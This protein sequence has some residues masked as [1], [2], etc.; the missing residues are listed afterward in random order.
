MGGFLLGCLFFPFQALWEFS[1]L[2][3]KKMKKEK[4]DKRKR[5][6]VRGFNTT[7]TKKFW[8]FSASW[9]PDFRIVES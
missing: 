4:R 5:N 8:D 1:F 6:R 3:N 9:A 2:A 7:T